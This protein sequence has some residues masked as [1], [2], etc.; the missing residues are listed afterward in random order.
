MNKW[1][2][3]ALLNFG[4]GFSNLGNW[5]YF[6]AINL[7]IIQITG[8]AAAVAGYFV[9]KPIAMLLTNLWAGSVIDRVNIRKLMIG[10]DV[11]RGLL[12]AVIP[13]L[14]SI[15]MIYAVTFMVSIAGSFFGPASN[16]YI[17]KLVP[18][19]RRQRFNSIMSMTNSGAFLLGPAISGL[20]INLT[21][22][23]FS[24]FFNAASFFLCAFFIYLLPNVHMDRKESRERMRFRMLV[25]DWKIVLRFVKASTFFT[26]IFVLIQ[27]AMFIGFSIDSQEA[28]YIKMHLKLSE[29]DYGN[30]LSLTG[31]G[32]LSGS[33][34]ATLLSKRLSYRLFITAGL[35][36]TTLC[37]LWFYASWS[38]FSATAAFMLLGFSMSFAS[39]GY[40]TFF[41]KHVP[42]DIMGRFGSLADMSQSIITIVLT[43]LVGFLS[44]LFSV[45][46]VCIIAAGIAAVVCGVLIVKSFSAAGSRF[47][48]LK[49][50]R[51]QDKN[52][53]DI[54]A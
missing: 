30:L 31:V 46:M 25:E 43:L 33:F 3:S 36:V 54:G 26:S 18:E 22:T 49:G 19:S 28:T 15:W 2:K 21:N 40:A 1:N 11:I 17:A 13:L 5:I 39:S 38:F 6:V 8:S 20:L 10:V 29:K 44:E 45:Q 42:A 51:L 47:F 4:I 12:I 41:Q 9:V 37:Y 35:L 53:A 14:P 24:I 23:S 50:E 7:L 27:V 16:V 32:S 34:L 48:L 52:G